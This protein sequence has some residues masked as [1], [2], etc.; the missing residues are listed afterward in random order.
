MLKVTQGH[1][2]KTHV[3]QFTFF[4]LAK[5]VLWKDFKKRVTAVFVD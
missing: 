5:Y 3:K 2:C 1:K 4:K